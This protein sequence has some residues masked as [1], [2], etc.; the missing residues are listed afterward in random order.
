[1]R[2]ND[3]FHE[4]FDERGFSRADRTNDPQVYITPSSFCNVLKDI[5]FLQMDPLLQDDELKGR[6]DLPGGAENGWL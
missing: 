5:D 6:G 4:T 3:R 2:Q 1:M